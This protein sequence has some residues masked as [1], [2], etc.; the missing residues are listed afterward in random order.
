MKNAAN[1]GGKGSAT[2]GGLASLMEGERRGGG[3]TAPKGRND[4]G[5]SGKKALTLNGLN[6][7]VGMHPQAG[8]GRG[9]SLLWCLIDRRGRESIESGLRAE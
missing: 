1:G 6:R 5:G 3:R 9:Q 4:R 7:L 2:G 8:R